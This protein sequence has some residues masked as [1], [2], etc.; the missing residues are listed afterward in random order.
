MFS[1]LEDAVKY[2]ESNQR[3]IEAYQKQQERMATYQKAHPDKCREK[4]V[5][6]YANMK[7]NEPEK[8]EQMKQQK[9]TRY[10][11]LK[12]IIDETPIETQIETPIEPPVANS[13]EGANGCHPSH[14]TETQPQPQRKR[15]TFSY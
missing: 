12:T 2:I 14:L 15:L 8:Y 4:A 11:A 9:R 10:K 5:K 13:L 7:A 6:Y 1:N 3:K